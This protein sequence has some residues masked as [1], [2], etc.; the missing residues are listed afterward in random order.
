M[1]SE[2]QTLISAASPLL[3]G[4]VTWFVRG[5]AADFRATAHTVTEHTTQLAIQAAELKRLQ[6]DN[7]RLHLRVEDMIGFLQAEGF[8]KRK[9]RDE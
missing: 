6:D 2:L 8:R 3:L 5:M 9:E 7:T 1:T 4:A